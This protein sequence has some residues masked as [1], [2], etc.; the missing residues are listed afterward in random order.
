M[1][2][3]K[4]NAIDSTNSYLKE[5]VR[6]NEL[7]NFTT[8]TAKNQTKGR[9]QMGSTWDSQSNKNLTFSTYI[10]DFIKKPESI[11]DLNC[12]IT[13]SLFEVLKQKQ[14]VNLSIKWPNDILADSK[15][16][17]GILIENI[18]KSN[19]NIHSIVGIGLNVNQKDFISLDTA[20]SI[21]LMLGVEIDT[22]SLLIEIL[23]NIVNNFEK[24]KKN[25]ADLFWAMYHQ[26]LFM[27]NCTCNFIDLKTNQPFT[28]KI[29][30]VTK[31]GMLHVSTN[32]EDK[33]FGIK[34]VKLI[35]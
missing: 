13:L 25:G 12:I 23:D 32:T 22:D 16:I 24:F 33:Y 29:I 30:G 31:Q 28:G 20:T 2:I 11:F 18:F 26:H 19:L 1:N 15:K 10:K 4:L 21:A 27:K 8:V 5:I 9:G 6:V 35:Y 17:A 7:E 34:E 3:I 14:L